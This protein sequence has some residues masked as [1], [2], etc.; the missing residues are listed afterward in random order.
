[1]PITL[2]SLSVCVTFVYCTPP[3]P[4]ERVVHTFGKTKTAQPGL[5][6]NLNCRLLLWVYLIS[7]FDL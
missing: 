5:N 4:K 7:S 6:E 1:M 2:P 3:S